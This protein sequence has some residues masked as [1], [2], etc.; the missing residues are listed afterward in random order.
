MSDTRITHVGETLRYL[1]VRAF[2]RAGDGSLSPGVGRSWIRSAEAGLRPDRISAP[3]DPDIDDDGELH[4]AAAPVMAAVSDDLDDTTVALLLTDIHA[5]VI[6]RWTD[7]C[8]TAMFMDGFGAAPGFICDDRVVGTNSVGEAIFQRASSQVL[9]REHFADGLSALSAA[10]AVVTHPTTRRPL[11]VINLTC[12]EADYSPVMPALVARI[13]HETCE[14][15]RSDSVVSRAAS[16]VAQLTAAE[17]RVAD[18]VSEGLTNRE[19]ASLLVV[20]PHT[21]D[22]HL[23]QIFRKLQI[24]SRVELARLI[25]EATSTH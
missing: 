9:G 5:H 4:W 20:S 21:V 16:A 12:A 1:T 19:A 17:R 22:Y 7:S 11:G 8:A 13:A 24:Q 10:S 15:L 3:Y 2:G 14:R 6:D 25:A 23:R 18:L